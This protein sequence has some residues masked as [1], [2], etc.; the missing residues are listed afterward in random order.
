MLPSSPVTVL[1]SF[2]N[3]NRREL[4]I[5]MSSDVGL[6]VWDLLL[7][8]MAHIEDHLS[9]ALSRLKPEKLGALRSWYS[10]VKLNE[11]ATLLHHLSSP[12][13]SILMQSNPLPHS[14]RLVLLSSVLASIRLL[15]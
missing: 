9:S 1:N 10:Q 4:P 8:H 11:P 6:N 5:L 2:F 14:H 3:V 13:F 15:L 12:K 7:Q